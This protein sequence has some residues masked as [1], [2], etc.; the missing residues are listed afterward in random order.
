MEFEGRSADGR[1]ILFR[2]IRPDDK[3]HLVDGFNRLS[4]ESRYRRFFR[5][6]D[7]LSDDQLAYL[8]ELDFE[9]HYGWIAVL[10]DEDSWKGVGVARWVRI[11]GEPA[12]AESAVTVVDEFHGQGIG[13]TL[14]W[15]LARSAVEK[16][17]KAMRVWV[18]GENAPVLAILREQGV[19]PERWEAGVSEVDI[20]LPGD[21]ETVDR[22][23]AKILLKKVAAG[24]LH[25]EAESQDPRRPGTRFIDT[26]ARGKDNSAPDR[27]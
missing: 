4:E 8:T 11:P 14:L 9:D 21:V 3:T 2:P 23:P 20:P 12:V 1:R 27:T 16:G 7:H 13:S 15:L 6:I 26:P 10:Q 19:R 22:T 5:Q 17:V 25:V 24:E 18:Q